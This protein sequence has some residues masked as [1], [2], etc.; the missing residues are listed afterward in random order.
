VSV[1]PQPD[2]THATRDELLGLIT[3]QQQTVVA[4]Q[5][6]I[7]RLEQ[8]VAVLQA[9]VTDLERRLGS[10]GGRGMPGLKSP[11]QTRTR[12]SG[13]PRTR[14][15][16]ASVRHRSPPT[17]TVQH[18][19]GRCPDCG[20]ALRGGWLHRRRE[21]LELPIAPVEVVEHQVLA[22]HC[23]GCGRRVLPSAAALAPAVGV[24]VG[25]MRL[26]SRLV[27]LLVTLR[28][29]QRLPVRQIQRHRA[30]VYDLPLSLGTIV[31]ASQRVAAVAAPSLAEI[32]A[33]IQASPA[34]NL[35]ETGWRQ[36][37]QNGYVG[38]ASTPTACR[39]RYG[40]RQKHHVDALLGPDF[41][42]VLV[43]DFY[44][45]YAHY[46]GLKQKCWPHVLRAGHDLTLAYPDDRRLRRWLER[47]KRLYADAKAAAQRVASA[48]ARGRLTVA[49]RLDT[50][51]TRLCAAPADDPTAVHGRLCRR[52]L[53][54]A[55]ELFTFVA[56]PD[57][58]PD[59]N[60]AERSLR[61][62][63]TQRT[64]SGG[65][66]SGRGTTTVLD[67]ASLIETWRRRG[68]NPFHQTLAL[69]QPHQP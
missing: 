61:H 45:A 41:A 40:S 65:S 56:I 23:G 9:R 63:V 18:A 57:V 24:A 69:L 2:L 16:Q 30:T 66:R 27:S 26:G 39:F 53:R 44:A 37:G 32:E 11:T 46:P 6:V 38:T 5:A 58:P 34:V 13:Q 19:A 33:A 15:G 36:D 7:A 10:S 67:L 54:H 35:D 1:E 29:E 52:L 68:L 64:I 31:A 8:T 48:A 42:G 4:Q 47:L 62:L 12:A 25:R 14:R 20:T 51:L 60:G 55:G 3:H 17:R 28:S 50:R 59:N 22:R 43:S 21:V 49:R